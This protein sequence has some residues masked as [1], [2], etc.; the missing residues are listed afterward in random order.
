MKSSMKGEL[1]FEPCPSKNDHYHPKELKSLIDQ[2][3]DKLDNAVFKEVR[4]INTMLTREYQKMTLEAEKKLRD[5]KTIME[6]IH[7]R[8][9]RKFQK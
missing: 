5:K 3:I 9:I 8:E 2:K 1:E 6:N 7:A 4:V